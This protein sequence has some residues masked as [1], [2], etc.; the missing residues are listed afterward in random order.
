MPPKATITKEQI[1]QAAFEIIRKDGYDALNT[2]RLASSL[3]MST[4]P[5]FKYYKNIDEIKRA[6]VNL[7]VEEYMRYMQRGSN[8]PIPFKGIGRAYIK[9]AKEEPKL[10]E[11]F[12]MRPTESVL[13]LSNT[14]PS[15]AP[16]LDMASKILSGNTTGAEKLLR[17]MWIVVHGIATLEATGKYSFSDEEKSQ[18]LSTIFSG[19]KT[20]YG[21]DMHE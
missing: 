18:I 3:G 7:G 16:A 19:L 8:D 9:F 2:R 21:G 14:D 13:G 15:T 11:I 1:A 17:D 6:A 4:M 10:F 12:Y 5:L 20:Q